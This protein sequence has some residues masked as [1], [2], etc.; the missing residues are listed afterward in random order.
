MNCLI[1]PSLASYL[2]CLKAP[3]VKAEVMKAVAKKD[4][5]A[6]EEACLKAKIPRKF[7]RRMTSIVFS[8]TPDQIWPPAIWW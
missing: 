5:K 6:F 1:V 3:Q 4:T 2:Q 7:I 8:V